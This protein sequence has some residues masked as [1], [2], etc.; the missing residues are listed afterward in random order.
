VPHGPPFAF[1][2]GAAH[3]PYAVTVAIDGSVHVTG[4]EGLMRIGVTQLGPARIAALNRLTLTVRFASLPAVTHCSGPPSN[5]TTSWIRV[6]RKKVTV[7]GACLSGY[8]RLLRALK[9]A[10]HLTSSG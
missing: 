7:H 3:G 6:G 10:V 9:G 4:S 8:Q 2:G 5:S 1:G